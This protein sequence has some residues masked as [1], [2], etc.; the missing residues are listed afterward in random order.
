MQRSCSEQVEPPPRRARSH[1]GSHSR[2]QTCGPRPQGSTLAGAHGRRLERRSPGMQCERGG[3]RLP[4][5]GRS[6]IGSR[7]A[8]RVGHAGACFQ[9]GGAAVLSFNG[10]A[11]G[12]AGGAA[13]AAAPPA[14]RS[15]QFERCKGEARQPQPQGRALGRRRCGGVGGGRG[16]ARAGARPVAGRCWCGARRGDGLGACRRGARLLWDQFTP[17]TVWGRCGAEAWRPGR[18]PLAR[19]GSSAAGAAGG[20]DSTLSLNTWAPRQRRLT[21]SSEEKTSA[22]RHPRPGRLGARRREPEGGGLVAAV[23]GGL[24]PK[25]AARPVANARPPRAQGP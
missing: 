19:A 21:Q 6:P 11:A 8:Q 15:P 2:A 25:K 5:A 20:V 24:A 1:T 23:A 14:V 16:R 13:H 17:S 4:A 9:A 7:R 18:G 12:A 22:H 3:A 10:E